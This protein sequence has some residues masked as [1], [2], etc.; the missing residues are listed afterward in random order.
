MYRQICLREG[1]RSIHPSLRR[2]EFYICCS[3]VH[4]VC[5]WTVFFLI[6]KIFKAWHSCRLVFGQVMFSLWN[7]RVSD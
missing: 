6:V 2:D 1:H 4:S 5:I 3:G 7:A